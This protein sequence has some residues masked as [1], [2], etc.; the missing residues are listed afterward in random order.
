MLLLERERDSKTFQFSKQQHGSCSQHRVLRHTELRSKNHSLAATFAAVYNLLHTYTVA[1][2]RSKHISSAPG[3][4]SL[5]RLVVAI[6]RIPLH[7]RQNNCVLSL[8]RGTLAPPKIVQGAEPQQTIYIAHGVRLLTV[9]HSRR[10]VCF[11]TFVLTRKKKKKKKNKSLRYE[12]GKFPDFFF[13]FFGFLFWLNEISIGKLF[14][15]NELQ[16]KLPTNSI[17]CKKITFLPVCDFVH[18]FS[19]PSVGKCGAMGFV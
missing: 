6:A 16:R 9:F 2:T 15:A 13:R 5:F 4:L 19:V 11:T 8:S 10:L 7:R 12:K 1:F 18:R 17:R 3:I 14:A